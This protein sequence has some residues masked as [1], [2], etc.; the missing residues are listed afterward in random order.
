MSWSSIFK[1][2]KNPQKDLETLV[3]M[4]QNKSESH[5]KSIVLFGSMASGEFQESH[6]DINVLVILNDAALS[7][8]SPLAAIL[9]T[10]TDRGHPA[11]IFLTL[12]E[13]STFAR[14]LPI[15]F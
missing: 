6:S 14:A 7:T 5:L 3:Q 2:K 11:P 1:R 10:W 13:L 9:R 15:E 8:L 12:Q 4:L